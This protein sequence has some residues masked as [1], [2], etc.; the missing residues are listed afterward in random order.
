MNPEENPVALAAGWNMIGY[1]LK[2]ETGPAER[3][4]AELNDAGN[5]CYC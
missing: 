1:F 4:F 5:L 3:V 2:R